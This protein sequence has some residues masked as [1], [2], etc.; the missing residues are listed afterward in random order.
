M[1]HPHVRRNRAC[2][3][4][5][6]LREGIAILCERRERARGSGNARHARGPCAARGTHA[7]VHKGTMRRS[8]NARQCAG[9]SHSCSSNGP[10]RLEP[11]SSRK[12]CSAPGHHH[13]AERESSQA[14]WSLA[15]GLASLHLCSFCGCSLHLCSFCGSSQADRRGRVRSQCTCRRSAQPA[16]G[17]QSSSDK[18]L[19]DSPGHSCRWKRSRSA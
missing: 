6:P 4:Q 5:H 13:A 8:G 9:K 11:S 7:S 14:R 16:Q 3:F 12:T 2:C 18:I 17:K 1:R 19:R 10:E 15:I